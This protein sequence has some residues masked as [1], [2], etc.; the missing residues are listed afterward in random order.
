MF[1]LLQLLLTWSSLLTV[2]SAIPTLHASV[3]HER[4]TS[5]LSTPLP[6]SQDPFYSA[7]TDYESALPGSILRIRAAPGNLTSVIGNCSSAYN[8]L[9]RTTDSKYDPSWAVTTLFIPS[10][11][12]NATSCVNGTVEGNALLSYQIPYNS[13]NP[14]ASPSY[15]LYAGGFP[16]IPTA[17]DQGWYV[18]VPDFEGPLASFGLGVQEGHA[19][20]DSVRAVLS[21]GFGLASDARYAMWGYS[22]GSLASEW[23]AELQKQ[24]APELNFAGA[25]LG[26]LPPNA[27]DT[28]ISINGSSFAGLVPSILLG[29]TTQYPDAYQYLLSK[30]NP[31]GPYNASTF[32]SV[33]KMNIEEA[34]TA[35]AGQ[36]M[37]NYFVD[38]ISDIY[39]PILEAIFDSNV[40]MGYHGIP[41]MPMFMYKAIGDELSVIADTDVLV[42]R[43][44]GVGVNILYQRN[45]V[46]GHLAEYTNGDARAFAWLSNVLDGTYAEMYPSMGCT[47]QNVTVGSDTSP[48]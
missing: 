44:C 32:L 28:L 13:P 2:S 1:S 34:F 10:S 30:L 23:A 19:T 46:G 25:A 3:L 37:F 26:G 42:N 22:G 40:Y 35:F 8:I 16:D 31:A 4:E 45:T 36:N 18:N 39:V 29:L 7:P 6:P 21:S 12:S 15:A 38:G 47:I 5:S 41:Q 48:L 17:L 11:L 43:Y 27:T 33:T 24:Y 20:L 14:D 9:Y